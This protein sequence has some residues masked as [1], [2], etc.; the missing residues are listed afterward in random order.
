MAGSNVRTSGSSLNNQQ[1]VMPEEPQQKSNNMDYASMV[2]AIISGITELVKLYNSIKE[3]ARQDK[4]LTPEQ[5]LAFDEQIRN[6]LSQA[7]WKL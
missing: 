1:I 3:K 5:E 4:E 2:T 6:T 7:H